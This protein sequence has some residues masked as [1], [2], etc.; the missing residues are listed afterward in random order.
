MKE[1]MRE[2]TCVCLRDSTNSEA[3]TSCSF[4]VNSQGLYH[5]YTSKLEV[6][7][8]SLRL[9]LIDIGESCLPTLTICYQPRTVHHNPRIANDKPHEQR[10]IIPDHKPACMIRQAIMPRAISLVSHLSV[11]MLSGS[12]RVDCACADIPRTCRTKKNKE[13]LSL[14]AVKVGKLQRGPSYQVHVSCDVLDGSSRKWC[15]RLFHRSVLT[16]G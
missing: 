3:L 2:R 13:I 14:P 4:Q 12:D 16:I 7:F 8:S 11:C 10:R 5:A 9:P 1:H 6:Q 15:E